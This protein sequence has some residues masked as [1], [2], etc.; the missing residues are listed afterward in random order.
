MCI[1]NGT[2]IRLS[3]RR[4]LISI[5]LTKIV[6]LHRCEAREMKSYWLAHHDRIF[7]AM[8]SFAGLS[9]FCLST[10]VLVGLFSSISDNDG[11]PILIGRPACRWQASNLA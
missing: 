2:Q 3:D 1:V 6:A 4:V 7:A 8:T 11:K 5:S 10:A 9:N